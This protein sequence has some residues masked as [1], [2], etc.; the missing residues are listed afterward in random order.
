[1]TIL[2]SVLGWVIVAGLLLALL[3]YPIKLINRAAAKLPKES[4]RRQ[5]VAALTRFITGNHRFIAASTLVVLVVHFILQSIYRW[6]SLT[7]LIAVGLLLAAGGLGAFGHYIRKRKRSAWFPVHR[8]L[9]VLLAMAIAV[10]I[11]LLGLPAVLF[12]SGP[13]AQTSTTSQERVFTLAELARYDGQNGNPAYVAVDGIVYDVSGIAS[14]M[15]GLHVNLHVAGQD[16]S[17]AIKQA[18]HS[19]SLLSRAKRVGVLAGG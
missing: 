5:K 17:E 9:A 15:T 3:N 4:P 16:L 10:H 1:V 6:V 8:T 19:K 12:P 13:A 18:P 11:A 7:G 2:A 14:W